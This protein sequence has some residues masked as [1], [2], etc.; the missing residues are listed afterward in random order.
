MAL[1]RLFVQINCIISAGYKNV[2]SF[3][4][5]S[6]YTIIHS[7]TLYWALCYAVLFVWHSPLCELGLWVHI[8]CIGLIFTT[9][10]RSN[11]GGR[12]AGKTSPWPSYKISSLLHVVWA[13]RVGTRVDLRRYY[14]LRD[15]TLQET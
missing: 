8:G 15:G 10:C 5:L 1:R 6:D 14:R 12:L 3:G 9:R 4:A 2:Y 7:A 11:C 13:K